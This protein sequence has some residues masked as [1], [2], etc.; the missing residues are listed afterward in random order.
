LRVTVESWD[1]K[2][3]RDLRVDFGGRVFRQ[4]G[5]AFSMSKNVYEIAHRLRHPLVGLKAD[6]DE[7]E[8]RLPSVQ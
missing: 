3:G 7:R 6:A 1:G 8:L 5:G 4:F 2:T